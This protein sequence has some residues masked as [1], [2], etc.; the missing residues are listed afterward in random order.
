M[1]LFS[2]ATGR[3]QIHEYHYPLDCHLPNNHSPPP[4]FHLWRVLVVL[5]FFYCGKYPFGPKQSNFFQLLQD[6]K[7]CIPFFVKL[8]PC[9]SLILQLHSSWLLLPS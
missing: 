2:L 8:V 7:F 4:Y 5:S 6:P 9:Q 1:D 3:H